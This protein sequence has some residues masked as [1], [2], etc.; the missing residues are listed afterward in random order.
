MLKQAACC[1]T[2]R[3]SSI[4]TTAAAFKPSE[5]QFGLNSAGTLASAI[6]FYGSSNSRFRALTDRT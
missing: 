5:A 3:S 6:F 2:G 1:L 4:A